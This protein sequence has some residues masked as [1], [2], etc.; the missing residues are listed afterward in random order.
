MGM[1]LLGK[2]ACTWTGIILNTTEVINIT[3]VSVRN[4]LLSWQ[5]VLAIQC[6][7]L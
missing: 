7:R 2:L 6:K 5:E 4:Q 1:A 3:V